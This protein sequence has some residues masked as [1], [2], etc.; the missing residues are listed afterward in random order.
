MNTEGTESGFYLTRAII[1]NHE[2]NLEADNPLE[3][4]MTSQNK[5][6]HL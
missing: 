4:E 3:G 1:N 6:F 2:A 5:V